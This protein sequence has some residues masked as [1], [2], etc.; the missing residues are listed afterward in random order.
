M[1]YI[2]QVK[3]DYKMIDGMHGKEMD[4][5][6]QINGKRYRLNSE[7]TGKKE[8]KKEEKK[9]EKLPEGVTSADMADEFAKVVTKEDRECYEERKSQF[10]GRR[11]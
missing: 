6:Q 4:L 7:M 8:E 1:N 10:N 3:P 9:C 5:L 2:E 11:K